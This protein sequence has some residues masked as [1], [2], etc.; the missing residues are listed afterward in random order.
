MI[1]LLFLVAA[2]P[3]PTEPTIEDAKRFA[4]HDH[5]GVRKKCQIAQFYSSYLSELLRNAPDRATETRLREEKSTH[6]TR[7]LRIYT[8]LETVVSPQE[9]DN[10]KVRS[11]RRLKSDLGEKAF[12]KG[13]VPPPVPPRRE[14]EF[15]AWLD[16]K[17]KEGFKTPKEIN[18]AALRE[19]E[20]QRK[21]EQKK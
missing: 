7:T 18:D 8:Y 14:K 16:K 17:F 6:L 13:E 5:A 15:K 11:L 1:A 2:Q 10:E 20:A 19:R 3:A 21:R 12:L 4:H 9:N